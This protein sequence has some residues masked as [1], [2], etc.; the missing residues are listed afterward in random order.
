MYLSTACHT[1]HQVGFTRGSSNIP[2]TWGLQKSSS[3]VPLTWVYKAPTFHQ[4]RFTKLQHSS[5]L[6]SQEGSNNPPTWIYKKTAPTAL[7][8]K[9]NCKRQPEREL[10]NSYYNHNA[11]TT[12]TTS[13]KDSLQK[14][15]S[16]ELYAQ[17]AQ[18]I[19]SQS[20]YISNR[21]TFLQS[22]TQSTNL[23]L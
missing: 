4:L 20:S 19:P 10:P 11:L 1:I 9:T 5:D 22:V 17:A 3:N 13:V 23:R 14:S 7:V 16:E 12:L 18:V 2:P 8:W 15:C 6:G 21:C